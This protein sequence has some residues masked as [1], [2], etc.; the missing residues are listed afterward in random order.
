M[1]EDGALRVH[2]EIPGD[3]SRRWE[4]GV[5]FRCHDSKASGGV[6]VGA[7]HLAWSGEGSSIATSGADGRC[8]LWTL[9]KTGRGPKLV[10]EC[11]GPVTGVCWSPDDRRVL[12][13]RGN[14]VLVM[15]AGSGDQIGQMRRWSAEAEAEDV[16]CCS[17]ARNRPLVA[18]TSTAGVVTL[19][20]SETGRCLKPMWGHQLQQGGDGGG[21]GSTTTTTVRGCHFTPDDRYLATCDSRGDVRV[22]DVNNQVCVAGWRAHASGGVRDCRFSPDG[23]W[24]A[25]ASGDGTCSLW[26]PSTRKQLTCLRNA[27]NAGFSSCAFSPS[28]GMLAGGTFSTQ[29]ELMHS[30]GFNVAVLWDGKYGI[31]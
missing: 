15:D 27:G 1:S 17:H 12:A 22:W 8:C 16:C 3:G 9:P 31:A 2:R 23:N 20:D 14:T 11:D 10:M 29:E 13:A 18:T 30:R 21:G 5:S 4:L 25:T 28:G 7:T 19:W 24:V 26:D 6:G